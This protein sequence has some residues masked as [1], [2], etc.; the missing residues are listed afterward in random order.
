M[1]LS[2]SDV[3]TWRL[4][5]DTLLMGTLLYFCVRSLRSPTNPK[6]IRQVGEL[7]S[8]LKGLIR[9]AEASGKGLNDQL[10]RR[11]DAL[12]KVLL[13]LETAEQR[14][15]RGMKGAE[16]T[17]MT[18]EHAVGKAHRAI[19]QLAEAIERSE[20]AATNLPKNDPIL[21]VEI[22]KPPSFEEAIRVQPR[23]ETRERSFDLS[24]A[25]SERSFDPQPLEEAPR[26]RPLAASVE[27]HVERAPAD[28]TPLDRAPVDRSIG[29]ELA[30]VYSAAEQMLR[31]GEDLHTVHR[32]TKLPMEQ[33]QRLSQLVNQEGIEEEELPPPPKVD[34]R[35]GV[36]GGASRRNSTPNY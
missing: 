3:T 8:T 29:S 15:T 19:K 36:L 11:Q 18:L 16:D 27:R 6:T 33:V 23:R 17:G 24:P 26:S 31:A 34:P 13:D 14:I 5:A 30:K 35:L 32:R 2:F 9:E 20:E 4:L 25:R 1:N 22:P 21:P 28:R 7:E 10:L 12:E